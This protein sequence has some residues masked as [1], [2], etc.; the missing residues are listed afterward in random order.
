MTFGSWGK[1]RWPP[2]AVGV[3][4][5]ASLLGGWG[6]GKARWTLAM[7]LTEEEVKQLILKFWKL[8]EEK[9]HIVDLMEVAAP[10]LEISMGDF[11]WHGYGGLGAHQTGSKGRYF[12]EH[13][14]PQ[15]ASWSSSTGERRP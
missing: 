3:R 9:A 15:R 6:R 8:D 12:D 4:K 7:P 13:F 10:D 11:A 5:A 2:A 14:E 1:L